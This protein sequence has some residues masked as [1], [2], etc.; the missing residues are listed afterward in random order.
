MTRL[1]GGVFSGLAT[2]GVYVALGLLRSTTGCP[3]RQPGTAVLALQAARGR[4]RARRH[5]VNRVYEEGLY[6]ND[7]T[8]FLARAGGGCRP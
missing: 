5:H 4:A 8:G 1:V 2:F 7:Y 3:W 6:F